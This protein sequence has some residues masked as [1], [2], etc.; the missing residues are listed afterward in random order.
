M[1]T[2]SERIEALIAAGRLTSGDR[3]PGKRQLAAKLD[4]AFHADQV[5]IAASEHLLFVEARLVGIEAD[6]A[7][8]KRT[9]QA[10]RQIRTMKE[11]VS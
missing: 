10:L 1:S 2:L 7:R 11:T 9:T 8:D 5:R 6:A 4:A 3:L